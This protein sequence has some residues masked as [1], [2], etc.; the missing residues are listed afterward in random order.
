ME[1]LKQL[2]KERNFKLL[3]FD[4]GGVLLNI[5]FNL[6]FEAFTQFGIKN[7]NEQFSQHVQNNFFDDFEKGLIP[8]EALYSMVRASSNSLLDNAVVEKAWNALLL[9]IPKYRIDI[10]LALKDRTRTCLLSNTNLIHYNSYRSELERIHGFQSFNQI[11]HK[12]YFSHEIHCRKPDAIAYQYV[13]QQENIKP[14]QVIF[15]DDTQK[16]IDAAKQLG[17]QAVLWKNEYWTVLKEMLDE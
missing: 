11:F 6:S 14:E 7:L 9:D 10:L 4:F 1:S 13:L 15:F 16:N 17:I 5:D 8:P 3:L 2:L 12:A